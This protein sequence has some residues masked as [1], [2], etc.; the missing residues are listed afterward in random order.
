LTAKKTGLRGFSASQSNN[1]LSDVGKVLG[2]SSVGFDSKMIMMPVVR[3]YVSEEGENWRMWY[4][5]R[6][7]E[8]DSKIVN[9]ASGRI[10]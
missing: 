7:T 3:R 8:F 6:D 10:G 9:L 1:V 4:N 5:G 2:T